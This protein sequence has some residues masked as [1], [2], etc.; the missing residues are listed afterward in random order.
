MRRGDRSEK[1]EERVLS[2]VHEVDRDSRANGAESMV[3]SVASAERDPKGK[4]AID[5]PV[6]TDDFVIRD[7]LCIGLSVDEVEVDSAFV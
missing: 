7:R 4:P 6:D 1:P 3:D 2:E 5:G